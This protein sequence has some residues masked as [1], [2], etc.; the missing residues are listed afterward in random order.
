MTNSNTDVCEKILYS[1]EEIAQ[2]CKELGEEI[3]RDYAGKEVTFISILNGAFMF[4][5]DLL[6]NIT[7]DCRIDFM[8]V[9]TYGDGSS[10]SGN[11]LVKKGLSLDIEGRD[12]VIVEDILD[13]GFTMTHLL[14]HLG[15][16]NPKSL[17]VCTLIDKPQRREHDVSAS[18]VGFTMEK[19]YFIVGYGLDYAQQFRNLPY[20]GILK[21]D[22]YS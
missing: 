11:F 15:S 16:F 18:Y 20:I 9:S 3:S 1:K 19:E 17:K 5:A 10:T 6:K 8:Q 7:T 13:T 21:S 14:K 4:T 2:R 22:I 12:V